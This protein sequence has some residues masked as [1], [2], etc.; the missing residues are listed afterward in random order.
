MS[1]NVGW[2]DIAVAIIAIAVGVL[3]MR[4]VWQFFFCGRRSACEGCQ[5][6]CNRR[7]N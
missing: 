7:H 6:E 1:G 2:Q 3:L 5:K 4:R